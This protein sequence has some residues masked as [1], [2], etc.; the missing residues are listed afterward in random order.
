[1]QNK[2]LLNLLEMRT[3]LTFFT[4]FLTCSVVAQDLHQAHSAN[5]FLN[6]IGVNSAIYRRAES[7]DRTIE[8][9]NYLGTHQ[10]SA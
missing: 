9:I 10:A 6:S 3:L 8:C 1:M 2:N 4:L 7:V 5:D